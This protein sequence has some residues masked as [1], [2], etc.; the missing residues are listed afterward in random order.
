MDRRLENLPLKWRIAQHVSKDVWSWFSNFVN[1]HDVSTKG[2]FT[3]L[4]YN[5]ITNSASYEV[6]N[7]HEYKEITGSDFYNYILQPIID[8][9]PIN[10]ECHYTVDNKTHWNLLLNKLHNEGYKW[11]SGKPFNLPGH[12]SFDKKH[13]INPGKGVLNHVPHIFSHADKIIVDFSQLI[14]TAIKL[15]IYNITKKEVTNNIQNK[16]KDEVSKKIRKQEKEPVGLTSTH[17]KEV[18][19]T[20]TGRPTGSR[21][22]IV[23]RKPE[24]RRAKITGRRI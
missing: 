10:K 20:S 22:T 8:S 13:A 15:D 12:I 19:V 21:I 6:H 7:E 11:Y 3:Y 24:V 14:H 1:T 9:I 23:R 18:K 5:S 17:G 4:Y 2:A 16:V